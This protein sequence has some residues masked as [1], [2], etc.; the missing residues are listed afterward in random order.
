MFMTLFLL[1]VVSLLFYEGITG[2]LER[3]TRHWL[4]HA[5]YLLLCLIISGHLFAAFGVPSLFRDDPELY[6]Y[7]WTAIRNSPAMLGAIATT[8]ILGIVWTFILLTERAESQTNAPSTKQQDLLNVSEHVRYLAKHGLPYLSLL[9]LAVVSPAGDLPHGVRDILLAFL[10]IALG[11]VSAVALCFLGHWG[12]R[13]VVRGSMLAKLVEPFRRLS[14]YPGPDQMKPGAAVESPHLAFSVFLALQLII[15]SFVSVYPKIVPAV[16]VCVLIGWIMLAYYALMLVKPSIRMPVVLALAAWMVF[17]NGMPYKYTF[18]GFQDIS[19]RSLYAK[20]CTLAIKGLVRQGSAGC[21]REESS[22]YTASRIDPEHALD[23]WKNHVQPNSDLPKPTLVVVAT[24]GGAYRAAFWTAVVLDELRDLSAPKEPLEGLTRGIRLITGASGGMVGAAYY[25][26]LRDELG[27]LIAGRSVVEQLQA[28]I[29][30]AQKNGLNATRF[31]ISRDSLSPVAQELVQ[32]DI[33]DI[34]IPLPKTR[35]RGRILE[36]QWLKLKSTTYSRLA[37][38]EQL[39][40]TPSLVLSPMLVETGQPLLISNLDL[41]GLE[42]A[43]RHEVVELFDWFPQIQTSFTVATGVRMNATFPYVSPA[44][45]LPTQP[46]RRVVDAG[47]YDNFGVDLAISLLEHNSDWIREN[48]ERVIIIQIR[49]FTGPTESTLLPADARADCESVEAASEE[50]APTLLDAAAAWIARS[51]QWVTSPAE[52]VGGAREGG[53]DFRNMQSYRRLERILEPASVELIEFTNRTAS[54]KVAMSWYL[55]PLE[56]E[57]IKG[58]WHSDKNK[59]ELN[60]LKSLWPN[61]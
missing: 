53:T 11:V 12:Y 9:V 23:A 58:E 50:K 43:Q 48:V 45:S 41:G 51:L 28:D 7:G 56:L 18:P 17:A 22:S 55:T 52:G 27:E 6:G 21:S 10:G 31:P 61:P 29:L 36:D 33:R 16:A 46:E 38:A 13:K 14:R 59:C 8:L 15:L 20:D 32:R 44:V 47:Y 4:L 25:V 2:D 49:A 1:L 26:V 37:E 57:H 60:R 19:K 34:A 3:I 5:V 40:T 42:S 30:E 24:S 54:K 39:G 35:D